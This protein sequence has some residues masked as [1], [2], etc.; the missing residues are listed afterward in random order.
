MNTYDEHRQHLTVPH[1]PAPAA[2]TFTTF[3]AIMESLTV[4]APANQIGD[5]QIHNGEEWVFDGREWF[6]AK[7]YE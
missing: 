7:D 3:D 4:Q 6:R 1:N 2:K 5:T